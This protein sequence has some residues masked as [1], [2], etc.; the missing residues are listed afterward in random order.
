MER[1]VISP[2]RSRFFDR[3][4]F[5]IVPLFF[6]DGIL[7]FWGFHY[8]HLQ[9]TGGLAYLC[10]A[11]QSLPIVGFIVVVGFY[12]A[13]EKDDFQRAIYIQSLLWGTGATL[14]VTTFWGSME[15]YSQVPHMDVSLVQFVFGI[16]MSVAAAV[17]AWRYR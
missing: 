12:L 7:G 6:L 3:F 5:F 8:H 2:A 16:V 13:E 11:L 9:P 17:N 4:L 1:R 14:A 10:A 15:K